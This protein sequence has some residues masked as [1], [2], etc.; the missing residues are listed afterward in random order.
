MVDAPMPLHPYNFGS[1]ETVDQ[2]TAAGQS[3]PPPAPEASELD[4]EFL[5][6][7]TAHN[8]FND[9]Y[10]KAKSW[11]DGNGMF[12]AWADKLNGPLA[13]AYT[14]FLVLAKGGHDSMTLALQDD[15]FTNHRQRLPRNPKPALVAVQIV[16][17]PQTDTDKQACSDYAKYL[18]HAAR[19][20]VMPTNF[21]KAMSPVKLTDVKGKRRQSRGL[22]SAAAC[23]PNEA[24]AAASIDEPPADTCCQ[25]TVKDPF[26]LLPG[27]GKGTILV[28][29]EW[30]EQGHL[31]LL[32]HSADPE[33]A[34]AP[35]S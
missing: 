10:C 12:M 19:M 6:A 29:Y 18:E 27:T 3:A 26:N 15:Y 7:A 35:Q 2:L 13:I 17:R 23:T 16:A 14:L 30:N 34:G 8:S 1:T 21:A 20:E 11:N 9:V 22:E 25:A 28:A 33:P 24:L 31:I 5:N 32:V 4:S